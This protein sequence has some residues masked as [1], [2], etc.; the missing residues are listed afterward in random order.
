MSYPK[1]NMTE[2]VVRKPTCI[3]HTTHRT[4]INRMIVG[5]SKLLVNGSGIVKAPSIRPL[6]QLLDERYAD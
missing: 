3:N 5:E 2:H 6:L 1:L 4:E